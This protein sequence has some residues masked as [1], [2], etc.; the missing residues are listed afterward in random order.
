M[1]NYTINT[2]HNLVIEL[3]YCT[4]ACAASIGGTVAGAA[5][6]AVSI[7]TL[8]Q[9]KTLNLRAEKLLCGEKIF[10]TNTYYRLVR[11][12]NPSFYQNPNILDEDGMISK[13][14]SQPIFQAAQEKSKH[15]N[16]LVKHVVSRALYAVGTCV[17]PIIRITDVALGILAAVISII[18]Y[19][20]RNKL[21]NQ[22]ALRQLNLNVVQDVCKGIRGTVNPQ[23]IFNFIS[24]A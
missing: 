7:L 3:P 6:S 8:G 14:I 10:F 18:P 12:I 19:K 20:G 15:N 5:L 16:T 4:A 24:A 2:L 13:Y 11:V 1:F 23:Q 17:S 21:I 22:F 9:F